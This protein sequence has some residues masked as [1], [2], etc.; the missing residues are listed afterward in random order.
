MQHKSDQSP[1]GITFEDDLND[2]ISL[3]ELVRRRNGEQTT[4]LVCY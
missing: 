4:K 3:A 2:L 1:S